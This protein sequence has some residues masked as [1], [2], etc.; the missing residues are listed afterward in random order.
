MI[1]PI[2]EETRRLFAD[3]TNAQWDAREA[4]DEMASVYS[5]LWQREFVVTCL[6][7]W[8]GRTLDRRSD[9]RGGYEN[10]PP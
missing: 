7:W 2:I 1:L 5:E 9:G 3:R 6:S 4:A 10:A 8:H